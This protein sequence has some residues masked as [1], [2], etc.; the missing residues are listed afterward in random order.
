M[1]SAIITIFYLGVLKITGIT[2]SS[3]LNRGAL[4]WAS[5]IF[6][7]T[8]WCRLHSHYFIMWQCKKLSHRFWV[9][10]T[11]LP[12]HDGQMKK[13]KS[14]ILSCEKCTVYDVECPWPSEDAWLYSRPTAAYFNSHQI[15]SKMVTFYNSV[16]HDVINKTLLAIS[17]FTVCING[18]V[19]NS[20]IS[21]HMN[22]TFTYCR[23]VMN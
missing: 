17:L 5:C 11:Y 1:L 4:G 2:D 20:H 16:H 18:Y 10:T 12:R 6:N 22:L 9:P 3:I 15:N 13:N 23:S 8:I 21:K 14:G 7:G 19:A